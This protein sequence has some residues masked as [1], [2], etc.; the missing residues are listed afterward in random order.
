MIKHNSGISTATVY[1]REE[2]FSDFTQTPMSFVSDNDWS[3]DITVPTGNIEYYIKAETNSGKSLTRPIVAPEGYWTINVENLSIEDWASKNISAPYPNPTYDNVS[4]NLNNVEGSIKISIYNIL[5][6]KLYE[7]TIENGNGIIVL[8]LNQNW[9]GALFIS[10]EGDF[11]RIN[12]K[13]I[14]L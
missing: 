13:V 10:F 5:S 8:D 1:W 9:Q 7:T 6:Q 14:K 11:G 4:F 2:G 3:T 12:K